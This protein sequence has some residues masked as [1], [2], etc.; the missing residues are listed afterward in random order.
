V[1]VQ[2]IFKNNDPHQ[3]GQL[4]IPGEMMGVNGKLVIDRPAFGDKAN[5]VYA[6]DQ[7]MGGIRQGV[8][9]HN[10][11]GGQAPAKVEDTKFIAVDEQ[12]LKPKVEDTKFIAMDEQI[13]PDTK[14]ISNEILKKD[15]PELPPKVGE[16][17]MTTISPDKNPLEHTRLSA[18]PQDSPLVRMAGDYHNELG[19]PKLPGY[20]VS[21]TRIKETGNDP[22]DVLRF[23]GVVTVLERQSP[24]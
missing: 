9:N 12:F 15:H 17:Q 4:E 10:K 2:K 6:S 24:A 7:I 5:T 21:R 19:K 14:K 16:L 11:R 13:T 8:A 3:K 1:V 20:D 22:N 23:D 18:T